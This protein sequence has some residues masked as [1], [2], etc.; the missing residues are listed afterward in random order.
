MTSKNLAK[1]THR[2]ELEQ[3]PLYKLSN[4]RKLAH[5][6]ALDN[7]E[8]SI[9][10]IS[11]LTS[12]YRIFCDRESKRFITEPIDK[13]VLIHK[14]LLNL[15][16]RI[17]PP[18]YIHSAVKRRSYLSNATPHVNAENLLKI[19]IKKF[20]PSIKF[21]Y[22]YDFFFHVLLCSKDIATILSKLCTVQTKKY[23]VHL[24]TGS[25]ISPIL[26]FWANRTLFDKLLRISE[27]YDCK[28]TVY[29]DDIT[30]SGTNATK[31][32]LNLIALE[33]HNHGYEYHKIKIFYN[34]PAL[35]TG[36]VVTNGK[37]LL[38]H[39]RVRMIRELAKL[40]NFIKDRSSRNKCLASL[41][42]RLSEAEQINPS[43]KIMRYK[44]MA[45][46]SKEW[47]SI[48][49]YRLMKAHSSHKKCQNLKN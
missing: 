29:V 18:A 27:H 31:E 42:G 16:R 37:L 30:I 23:G 46:Y 21:R 43:F 40:L 1:A 4:K 3:S 8:I 44:M 12:Q 34:E 45:K 47:S 32:L 49:N 36:L 11:I 5:L 26:S 2:Y 15:L 7:A 35:V 22:I 24:P 39:K 9:Q 38:P 13:L 48:V 25:C 19:D 10:G 6:L 41:I 33:I 17:T 14:R 20:F 28:F